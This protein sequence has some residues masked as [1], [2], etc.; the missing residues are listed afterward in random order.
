VWGLY[1]RCVVEYFKTIEEVLAAK[2]SQTQR[3]CYTSDDGFFVAEDWLV[4]QFAQEGTIV[5]DLS[6]YEV[7]SRACDW[8]IMRTGG[9]ASTFYGT[10]HEV[11]EHVRFINATD[12]SGSSEI[13]TKGMTLEE[14]IKWLAE[15]TR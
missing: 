4:K 7:V 11:I 12:D 5:I 8:G 13:V 10:R 2:C 14:S 6:P 15:V 1:R 3:R 9:V